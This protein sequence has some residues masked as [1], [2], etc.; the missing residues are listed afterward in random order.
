MSDDRKLTPHEVVYGLGDRVGRDPGRGRA[1]RV[2]RD[3]ARITREPPRMPLEPPNRLRELELR[4]VHVLRGWLGKGEVGG[5]NKGA[6]VSWITHGYVGAWC[7][8]LQWRAMDEA[9]TALGFR[10]PIPW[11]RKVHSARKLL[12]MI[13][14]VG[15][16]VDVEELRAGDYLCEPRGLPWQ[17]HARRVVDGRFPHLLVLDG[18]VG[19]YKRTRGRVREVEADGRTLNLVGAARLVA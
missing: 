10:N 7:A 11:V 16:Y 13:A 15:R 5:N 17:G 18:N 1:A 19:V 3:D 9:A 8:A 4:T 14:E 6:W 12:E 2:V